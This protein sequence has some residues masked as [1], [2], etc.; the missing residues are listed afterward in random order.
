MAWKRN[1]VILSICGLPL[2]SGCG[3]KSEP[4]ARISESSELEK[5]PSG[6]T[7]APEIPTTPAGKESSSPPT[8]TPAPEALT[9]RKLNDIAIQSVN[10]EAAEAT[11]ESKHLREAVMAVLEVTH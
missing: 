11:M 1:L 5:S 3:S 4:D 10:P 7:S 9:N 6:A 2:L 8:N